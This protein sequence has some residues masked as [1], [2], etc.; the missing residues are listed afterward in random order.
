[1]QDKG[2]KGWLVRLF[3]KRLDVRAWG[4]GGNRGNVFAFAARSDSSSGGVAGS[5]TFSFFLEGKPFLDLPTLSLSLPLSLLPT[6]DV[7]ARAEL[8][9]LTAQLFEGLW[10]SG[11]PP[12]MARR[13]LLKV[14][15]PR[16][17]PGAGIKG[18]RR[19]EEPRTGATSL[20]RTQKCASP[21]P[22]PRP[23][24]ATW[25]HL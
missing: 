1:M 8:T 2:G 18:V 20:K 21:L 24:P 5:P 3:V 25:Q 11:R 6:P 16:P 12:S 9:R 22:P 23:P 17:G 4:V 10:F 19:R 13:S 14:L 15:W 7:G